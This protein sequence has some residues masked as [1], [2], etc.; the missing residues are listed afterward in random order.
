MVKADSGDK[1]EVVD[2]K[3]KSKW[4]RKNRETSWCRF[5]W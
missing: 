3:K 5:K 1:D 4:Y 2:K